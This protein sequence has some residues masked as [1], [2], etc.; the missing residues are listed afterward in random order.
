MVSPPSRARIHRLVSTTMRN[1]V[2]PCRLLSHCPN[3]GGNIRIGDIVRWF[4]LR[5][6]TDQGRQPSVQVGFEQ[7]ARKA[8]TSWR[9]E[10][11]DGE[12]EL[13]DGQ[14]CAGDADRL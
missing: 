7:G 6:A 5:E 3:L 1:I 8:S 14:R 10:L 11:P 9:I 2:A 12:N 4:A 13:I